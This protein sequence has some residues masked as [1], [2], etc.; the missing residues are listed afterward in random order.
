MPLLLSQQVCTLPC[1]QPRRAQPPAVRPTA[2]PY[3]AGR[4]TPP[5]LHKDRLHA[6]PGGREE[7]PPRSSPQCVSG[8]QAA[9]YINMRQLANLPVRPS[10][11]FSG[12]RLIRAHAVTGCS[13]GLEIHWYQVQP[14]C[15]GARPPGGPAGPNL[16]PAGPA[17]GPG[18]A[19]ALSRRDY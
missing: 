2:Q 12:V 4:P 13:V 18:M 1:H 7:S 11:V 6:T 3:T 8:A 15:F 14:F 9:D 17:T 5:R 19:S 16:V 10:T